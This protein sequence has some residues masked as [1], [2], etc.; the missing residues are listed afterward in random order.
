MADI[1]ANIASGLSKSDP[2]Y[3]Q[4][5]LRDLKSIELMLSEY[6]EVVKSR[7]V[8]LISN[9]NNKKELSKLAEI[10]IIE[11]Q[12]IGYTRE[13]IRH[14]SK[15]GLALEISSGNWGAPVEVLDKYFD[16]S[17]ELKVNI[18]VLQNAEDL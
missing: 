3:S 16:F 1:V 4:I 14:A 9:G 17:R 15:H 12:Q 13:Y 10:F 5:V 7:I 6:G 2:Q 8:A 11:C 18:S